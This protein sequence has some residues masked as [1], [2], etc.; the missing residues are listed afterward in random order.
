MKIAQNY[1]NTLKYFK[2]KARIVRIDWE[3]LRESIKLYF[4]N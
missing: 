1:L 3:I 2:I 4:K